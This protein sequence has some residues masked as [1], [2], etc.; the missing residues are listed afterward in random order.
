MNTATCHCSDCTH[1]PSW[2]KQIQMAKKCNNFENIT[3]KEGR[4]PAAGQ[5]CYPKSET[6][7]GWLAAGWKIS[8]SDSFSRNT[9]R[10]PTSHS[11]HN[12]N[13]KCLKFENEKFVQSKT[14][15]INFIQCINLYNPKS[16]CIN[17][18][19]TF[20]RSKLSKFIQ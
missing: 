18:Y 15:C 16:D 20:F 9:W 7:I 11:R 13:S 6:W 3:L 8:K 4:W 10:K 2:T 14:D 12:H 5:K 17:L 19:N 1:T